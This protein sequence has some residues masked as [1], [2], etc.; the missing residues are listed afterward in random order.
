[1]NYSKHYTTLIERAK[2]R[3]MIEDFELHHIL[4]RCLGGSD[5]KENL[6]K[7]TPEEHFVAHQ[8]LVNIYPNK[9]GL[10]YACIKMIGNPYGRRSNKLYGWLRRKHSEE[11]RSKMLGNSYAAGRIQTAEERKTRSD[12]LKEYYKNNKR[13][14]EHKRKNVESFKLSD[15]VKSRKEDTIKKSLDKANAKNTMPKRPRVI[16]NPKSADSYKKSVETRRSTNNG[17]WQSKESYVK[18]WETRRKNKL[19]ICETK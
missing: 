4:P 14:D 9:K 2:G 12:A 5:S 11:M 13:T 7:L 10:V 3:I 19:S 17:Q 16:K 1:M 18:M 6:V 15:K 8:L